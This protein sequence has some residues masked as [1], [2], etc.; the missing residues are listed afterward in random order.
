MRYSLK[1]PLYCL[2]HMSRIVC[3]F[4]A[5]MLKKLPTIGHRRGP[6]KFMLV[7]RNICIN[8]CRNTAVARVNIR[9]RNTMMVRVTLMILLFNYDVPV[10]CGAS[11]VADSQV[12][13]G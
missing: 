12:R 7:P 1:T 11:S 8:L 6:G 5:E 13:S 3:G 4:Q 10:R 2:C 9:D